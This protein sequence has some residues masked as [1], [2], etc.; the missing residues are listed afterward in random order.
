MNNPLL[1][2][3]IAFAV[4]FLA[5]LALSFVLSR[6]SIKPTGR[7]AESLEPYACGEDVKNHMIQP[8]YGQFL[9]FAFFF[10][11]LHVIALV[12]TTIPVAAGAGA[13]VI[14]G[15]YLACAVLGLY[16]LYAR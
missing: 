1:L 8:D 9:P 12:A 14:A 16:V 3:P 10:T 6:L 13:F 11:V 15:V 2:P 7:S 4:L 5:V